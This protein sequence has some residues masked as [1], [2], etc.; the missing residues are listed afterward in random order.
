MCCAHAHVRASI[1]LQSVLDVSSTVHAG[2][3]VLT[4]ILNPAL[5][6]VSMKFTDSSRALESPS[7]SDTC[8]HISAQCAH[9]CISERDTN[10]TQCKRPLVEIWMAAVCAV[11]QPVQMLNKLPA[12]ARDKTCP[13]LS[14]IAQRALLHLLP[15]LRGSV[16]HRHSCACLGL[17]LTVCPPGLSCFPLGR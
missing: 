4:L 2:G 5:A 11:W 14:N 12:V 8:L 10:Q 1:C 3:H 7:S 6:L 16:T 15:E 9:G 17:L 13:L